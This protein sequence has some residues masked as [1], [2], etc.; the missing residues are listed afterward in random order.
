MKRE[1]SLGILVFRP[2]RKDSM[3]ASRGPVK[4][5]TVARKKERESGFCYFPGEKKKKRERKKGKSDYALDIIH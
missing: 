3:Y 1:R 5:K 4:A 2:S